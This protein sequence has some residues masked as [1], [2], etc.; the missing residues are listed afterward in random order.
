MKHN[1]DRFVNNFKYHIHYTV[2]YQVLREVS[3]SKPELSAHLKFRLR[4]HLT[5][6]GSNRFRLRNTAHNYRLIGQLTEKYFFP[7]QS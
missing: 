1:T 6:A 3:F 4:L 7:L 5:K 2:Q